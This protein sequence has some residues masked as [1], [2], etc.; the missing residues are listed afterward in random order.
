M[1]VSLPVEPLLDPVAPDAPLVLPE[2]PSCRQRSFAAPVMAS[3]RAL[4]TAELPAEAP[5]VPAELLVDPLPPL[6][7][8]VEGLLVL[9]D[10]E[11]G[12]GDVVDGSTVPEADPEAAPLTLPLEDELL[13]EG[14]LPDGVLVVDEGDVA[15][16]D[17]PEAPTLELP[18][19]LVPELP[20]DAPLLDDGLLVD[21]AQPAASAMSAAAVANDSLFNSIASSL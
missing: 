14:A 5:A 15:V 18:L 20:D 13:D 10:P 9:D 8:L 21:W 6:P 11:L 1:P 7:T 12:E 4:P 19:V 16:P 2:L 3:Q 17:P